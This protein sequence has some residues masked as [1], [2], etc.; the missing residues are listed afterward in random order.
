MFLASVLLCVN[1][2]AQVFYCPPFYP[3]L[4]TTLA[5]DSKGIV[6]PSRLTGG[7]LF[8][9]ELGGNGEMHGERKYS[10]NGVDVRYGF[11]PTEQKWFVC[12]YGSGG[13]I[14][15]WRE[16]AAKSTSCSMQQRERGGTVSAKA[17]C[18]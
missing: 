7:T 14:S 17:E 5:K 1:A 16:V 15:L 11:P 4:S 12:N 6:T 3:E 10:K 2:H 13:D 9:G 18:S 8:L